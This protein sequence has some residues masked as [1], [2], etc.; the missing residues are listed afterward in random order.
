[1]LR[2]SRFFLAAAAA[3]A[4]IPGPMAAG[5]FNIEI[6]EAEVELRPGLSTR[7]W[8]YNGTVPGSAIVARVGERLTVNVTNRLAA[9]TNIHWHGLEVP[10]DQDGPGIVIPPGGTHAYSF[11]VKDSGT[12]WYHSHQMPVLEQMDRGLYGAL[13]VAA[14]EDDRYSGDHV[15]VLDD[16]YLDANGERLPGTASGMME[17]YGNIETVNGKSGTAIPALDLRR[18]ELHKLRFINA[19]TAAVHRLRVGG[20]RF[21]VTHTDGRPL[22]EPYLTDEL[23]LYPA[24]RLDAE[25]AATG[26]PGKRYEIS[27]DRPRLGLRIPIRYGEGSVPP[28][29]SPFVPPA[30][31]AFPGILEAAPDFTL[32]LDSRMGGG[33][34]GGHMMGGMRMEWTING[35][36]FADAEPLKIRVGEIVKLRFRNNDVRMMHPMDHPMHLHGTGFQVV[37]VNGR[38]P[39]RETWKDTVAVPAGGYVDIAFVMRNPGAWMLHC[40][41]IDH[42]D[43][44]MMTMILAE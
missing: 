20:H 1:M 17:R 29:S 19:S 43:G 28:Q 26:E 14:P 42:E 32:V 34:M 6:R 13:I 39:E 37:A 22:S 24:E 25:L 44:G 41:I 4:L 9:A 31:R 21:R 38:R 2:S 33:M 3:A 8:T 30:S 35:R 12:Y 7:A 11:T 27:S 15:F 10:A 23:I 40:H 36:T 18:G 16:W 5:T